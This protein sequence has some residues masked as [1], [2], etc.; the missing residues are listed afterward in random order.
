M[1]KYNYNYSWHV[2][3]KSWQVTGV[4]N[5]TW[6][7][8][9]FG[10]YSSSL[11]KV[12]LSSPFYRWWDWGTENGSRARAQGYWGRLAA[13]ML[14]RKSGCKEQRGE[15]WERKAEQ[16]RFDRHDPDMVVR[17]RDALRTESPRF[18]HSCV[19]VVFIYECVSVR[20]EARNDTWALLFYDFPVCFS[21]LGLSLNIVVAN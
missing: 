9:S 18:S 1:L 13:I 19:Y 16:A 5:F 7:K 4:E 8:N 17:S 14:E 2:Y 20:V 15:G 3:N 6:S 21:T 11:R 12:Q 10:F